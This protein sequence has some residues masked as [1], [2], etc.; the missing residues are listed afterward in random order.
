MVV[1]DIVGTYFVRTF[2]NSLYD[3]AVNNFAKSSD[4]YNTLED[5]YIGAVDI[6]T[7][8]VSKRETSQ[9]KTNKSYVAIVKDLYEETK[10]YI[11]KIH[12]LADFIDYVTRQF[13]HPDYYSVMSHHASAKE[14][15]FRNI[16]K[17]AL[18]QFAI[19]VTTDEIS[20]VLD[21]DER[22]NNWEPNLRAWQNKFIAILQN[23]KTK[24]V[25]L[26]LAQKHGVKVSADHEAETVPKVVC[27]KMVAKIKEMSTEL[28]NR[29]EMIAK[30][31]KFIDYL[32][33]VISSRDRT[34]SSLITQLQSMGILDA[35]GNVLIHKPAVKRVTKPVIETPS[36]Q[37]SSP[38]PP[39]QPQQNYAAPILE[40]EY[41]DDPPADSE[42]EQLNMIDVTPEQEE[43]QVEPDQTEPVAEEIDDLSSSYED[44]VPD[45]E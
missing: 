39:S 45:D 29:E 4:R 35:G 6:Y 30:Q 16:L 31:T 14:T 23:E 10:K 20:V 43:P 1:F 33:T 18:G 5:A 17:E 21:K 22:Q 40:A 2:W 26:F 15:M 3:I 9:E 36:P 41:S 11:D 25:K 19:Y 34:I 24:L 38:Q 32:K 8:A 13:I 28:A 7:R 12:T 44:L 37:A 42:E 27:D